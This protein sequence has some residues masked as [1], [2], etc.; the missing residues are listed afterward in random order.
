MKVELNHDLCQGHGRCAA[1]APDLFELD[2]Y[3]YVATSSQE[4]AAGLEDAARVG[5]KAC[6]ERVITVHD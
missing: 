5:A 1:L 2:D 6:P 3:G 4:I